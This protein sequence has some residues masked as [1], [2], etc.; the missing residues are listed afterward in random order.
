MKTILVDA[1]YCFLIK[2]DDGKFWVFKELYDMLETFPNRKILLT[3]A[4]DEEI[5]G[6]GLDNVLYEYFT[7][8]MDPKKSDPKYYELMLKHFGLTAGD[9]VYFEHNIDAVESARAV[10]ITTYH[11]DNVKKDLGG[12]KKFIA[13]NL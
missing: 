2:G 5:E 4:R 13:E 7:L 6:Y 8:K 9:V 10:G 12:L 11:Y 1:V 3:G